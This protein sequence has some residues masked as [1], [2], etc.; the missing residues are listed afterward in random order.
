MR[1]KRLAQAALD[2]AK[3]YARAVKFA[4]L[5]R[6]ALRAA[7]DS[8]SDIAA[9]ETNPTPV[10]FIFGCGR[11][12]T[13]ILGHAFSA[14]P[15]VHYFF[16][17]YHL[18]AAIDPATDMLDLY[19]PGGRGRCMMTPDMVTEAMRSRFRR[20]IRRPRRQID[21]AHRMVIEKTPINAMRLGYLDALA[22]DA[23]FIHIVRDGVDVCRSIERLAIANTYRIAGKPNLNQ[24]WG[25]GDAKWRAMVRDGVTAGAYPDEIAAVRNHIQRG[26]YEWLLSLR[27]VDRWR[28]TLGPRLFEFTYEELASR[29]RETFQCLCEFLQ[30]SAPEPWLAHVAGSIDQARRNQGPAITLP[31][32]MA[33]DFNRFQQRYGFAGRANAATGADSEAA[34]TD[35]PPSDHVQSEASVP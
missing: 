22:P 28:S 34:C 4:R 6:R 2:R 35:P 25:V 18:W 12:G 8:S 7:E 30:V 13:T 24:W 19:V 16:E 10:A 3:P 31:T 27:E 23:K 17:P 5:Y 9:V 14:H 11:S 26:A 29:P 21:G 15:H 33:S 1:L 32:A 20:L